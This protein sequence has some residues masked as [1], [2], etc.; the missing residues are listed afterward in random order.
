MP[1]YNKINKTKHMRKEFA[2]NLL[3]DLLK[4]KEEA[5]YFEETFKMIW[6]VLSHLEN[7]EEDDFETN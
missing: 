7:K 5:V 1:A 6:D 3:K 4:S 2:F